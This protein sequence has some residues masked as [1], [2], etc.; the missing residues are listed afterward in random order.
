LTEGATRRRAVAGV[1]AACLWVAACVGSLGTLVFLNDHY[2][3]IS[4]ARQI[5]VYGELPFRDFF[6]PG[7]FM[8]ELGSAI[9]QRLLGDNLFGEALLATTFVATGT[10]LVFLLGL[11]ISH[12]PGI[13]LAASIGAWLFLPRAYD[14]DKIL[15]YPLGVLVCWRYIERPGAGSAWLLAAG[16]VAGA[17]FRYD[18]GFYVAVAAFVTLAIVHGRDWRT[19]GRRLALVTAAVIALSTPALTFVQVNGGLADAVDQMVTY[20]RRETARTRVPEAPAIGALVE[21]ARVPAAPGESVR[22]RIRWTTAEADAFLLALFRTL[23]LLAVVIVVLA[24]RS[25]GVSSA[26]QVARLASLIAMCVLLN[27][28]VLRD[29]VN[30]RFGG[31]AGPAA[32]L[33]AWLIQRAWTARRAVTRAILRAGVAAVVALTAWSAALSS[34]WGQ[35]FTYEAF[36]PAHLAGVVRGLTASPPALDTLPDRRLVGL[37]R[38]LRECTAPTDRVLLGWFAPEVYFYAQR[39]FAGAMVVVFG[40]HWSE[41]RFQRRSI[42]ALASQS[43]PLVILRAGD[44]SFARSYPLIMRHIGEHYRNAG[45]TAFAPGG[46]VDYTVFVRRDRP[47]S[48]IHAASSMP[49]FW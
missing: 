17:L 48:Y 13:A 21:A 6:D 24:V 20:G 1:A 29:P 28:F 23:P 41:E 5:A 8:P 39:G 18:T 33:A 12:S 3:R 4:P 2:G 46:Q 22:T 37:V 26:D 40:E 42:G 19:L 27:I 30:A 43:V 15:F 7:Y 34:D 14:Y 16:L 47:P 25:G 45:V 11:R 32:I 31:I 44:E 38:Y 49:C 35:R 9:L 10:V 36:R